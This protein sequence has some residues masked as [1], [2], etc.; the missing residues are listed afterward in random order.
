MD[1]G[2]TLIETLLYIA[3]LSF[4]LV[5]L[6]PLLINLNYWRSGEKEMQNAMNDYLF[7]ESTIRNILHTSELVEEPD[8][9]E[10]DNRLVVKLRNGEGVK[11]YLDSGRIWLKNSE[12][13]FPLHPTSTKVSSFSFLKQNRMNIDQ[14]LF[15]I[16][17]NDADFSTTTYA[18]K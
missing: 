4:L 17:I 5:A 11:I 1:K 18:I 10:L 16:Q 3:L 14:L 7:I 12:G 6:M 9:D 2:L 15:H 13:V 8:N